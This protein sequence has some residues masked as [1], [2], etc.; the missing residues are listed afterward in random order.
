MWPASTVIAAAIALALFSGLVGGLIGLSV[1]S[2]HDRVGMVGF[3]EGLAQR[4]QNHVGKRLGPGQHWQQFRDNH[5]GPPGNQ[6]QG[7]GLTG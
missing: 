3:Q 7:P 2:H 5:P 4:G 6:Q 1:A